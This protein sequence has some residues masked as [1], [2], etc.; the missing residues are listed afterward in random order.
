MKPRVSVVIP[1][2]NEGSAVIPILDRIFEAITL[3][4]E[5]LIV[6]DSPSDTTVPFL[7]TYAQRDERLRPLHKPRGRGPAQALRYGIEHAAADVVVVTM[8]DGSDDPMQIDQLARLVERGVVVACASR[9]MRGGQQVGGPWLKSRI[10]RLAGVSLNLVG[11]VGTH[12]ATNSFKAYSRDFVRRVGID[13]DAGF[14][15]GIEMI[16]KA[17]RHGLPVA[18]LPTIWLDRANGTSHFQVKSWIPRY[19][20]WYLHA[21]G[22]T[23]AKSSRAGG[24][25]PEGSA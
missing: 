4:A 24:N 18:E 11:R 6:Y 22:P 21:L 15:L 1:V 10:S 8:A 19:L 7:T 23:Q 16:A 2:Y 17:R 12:D 25:E 9:Y 20:H 5:V 13:S 3:P 14:E